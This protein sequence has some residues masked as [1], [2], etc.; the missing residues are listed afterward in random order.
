MTERRRA[1]VVIGTGAF[2]R[3]LCRALAGLTLPPGTEVHVVG[4]TPGAAVAVCEAAH[5]AWPEPG[6]PAFYP[7][8]L[9][10]SPDIDVR[11]LLRAVRPHTVVVCA[12]LQS[13]AEFRASDS[14]WARLVRTAGFAVTLPLQAAL[15]APIATACADA[16]PPVTMVNACFPDAVNPTLRARGLPVLCGL[17]NV[18]SLAEAVYTGLGVTDPGRV[19]LFAH[20]AHLHEPADPELEARC[21]LDD[22]PYPDVGGL[23]RPVRTGSRTAVND[24]GA[25]VSAEVVRTLADGGRWIGHLP[26]PLGLP[27]GFPVQ[28]EGTALTLRLP[29]GPSLDAHLSWTHR[30][31]VLDGADVGVDG[32]VRFAPQATVALREHLPDLPATLMPQELPEICRRLLDLRHRLR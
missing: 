26:G 9:P 6:A 7:V 8:D 31:A 19:K 29:P 20:H 2:S 22:E 16:D 3:A 28:L 18:G 5:A 25:T 12:S 4:R 11:W 32:T 14:G 24:A 13:P 15:A 23:L 17:G 21:W 30:V 1:I 27:G 10:L